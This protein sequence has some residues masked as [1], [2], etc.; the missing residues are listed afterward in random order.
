MERDGRSAGEAYVEFGNT[1][2]AEQALSKDRE[3]IGHRYTT[4]IPVKYNNH[5]I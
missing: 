4:E 2:I 1:D 3:T 5:L